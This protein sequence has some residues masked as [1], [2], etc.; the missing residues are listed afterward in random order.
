MTINHGLFTKNAKIG[1]NLKLIFQAKNCCDYDARVLECK[2]DTK[3]VHIDSEQEFYLP[4]VNES[5]VIAGQKININGNSYSL[6]NTVEIA[7]NPNNAEIRKVLENRY[8]ERFEQISLDI[9]TFIDNKY[10]FD[11]IEFYSYF[12]HFLF[13]DSAGSIHFLMD[14]NIHKRNLCKSFCLKS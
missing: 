5:M 3:V 7:L 13:D 4:I 6:G 11:I 14:L 1:K 9:T 8:L 10:F 2:V 12:I